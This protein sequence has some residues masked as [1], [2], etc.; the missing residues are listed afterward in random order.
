M[1][2]D[3]GSHLIDQAVVLFGTPRTVNCTL[4]DEAGGKSINEE[5]FVDDGFVILLGYDHGLNGKMYLPSIPTLRMGRGVELI[6]SSRA[7]F[8]TILRDHPAKA[9]RDFRPKRPM[10]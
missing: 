5:G 1:L 2:F 8:H 9:I 3:L 10:D 4:L 6:S 7:T